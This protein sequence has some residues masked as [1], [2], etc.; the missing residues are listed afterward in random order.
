MVGRL[1]DMTLILRAAAHTD[2]GGSRANNEDSVHAGAHLLAVADGMGGLPAGELASDLVIRELATLEEGPDGAT[3]DDPEGAA[4]HAL[5]ALH[6][7]VAAANERIQA[8]ADSDAAYRGMGTTVTALLL[9]GTRAALLHIGD[10]RCYLLRD[11]ELHQLT[12]DDTFVQLLVDR[13]V[14]TAEEARHHPQRSL[15]TRAVQGSALTSTDAVLALR[16]G[17]R[18]LL[19]SDG[20]SDT[21]ADDEIAVALRTGEPPEDSARRLVALAVDAGAGDNV[22]ALVADVVPAP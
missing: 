7:A 9:A 5:A 11:G 13:G 8:A 22:T 20:L 4:D 10:S 16:P 21:I 15:V 18:F 14:L 6:R 1:P 12:R 3:P 17:D 2:L 19:C